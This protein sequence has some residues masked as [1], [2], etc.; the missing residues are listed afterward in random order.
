[1]SY[2][3]EEQDFFKFIRRSFFKK[4]EFKKSIKKNYEEEFEE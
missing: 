3:K 4:K 1:M 2:T